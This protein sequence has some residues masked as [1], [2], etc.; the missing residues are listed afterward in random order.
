MTLKHYQPWYDDNR[1]YNTNAPSY[2]DYLANSNKL[3]KVQTEAINELLVRDVNFQD[4]DEIH[5]DKLTDWHDDDTEHANKTTFKAHVITSP[6]STTQTIDGTDYVASNGVTVLH[7]GLYAPDYKKVLNKFSSDNNSKFT[8]LTNDVNSLNSNVNTL[9]GNV[10]SLNNEIE[11]VKTSVT[12]KQNKLTATDG[13]TISGDKVS[14]KYI[15][16]FTGD[17]N[18]LTT[19]CW[20]KPADNA[21]NLPANTKGGGFLIVTRIDNVVQQTYTTID[22]KSTFIRTGS[23]TGTDT[24]N[25]L[26]WRALVDTNELTESIKNVNKSFNLFNPEI[27]DYHVFS[28]TPNASGTW[29]FEFFNDTNSK[30]F[31]IRIR[32]GKI[33]EGN[34]GTVI[35]QQNVSDLL[36]RGVPQEF[37]DKAKTE[38][39]FRAGYYLGGSMTTIGF[40]LKTKDDK[41]SLIVLAHTYQGGGTTLNNQDVTQ[42]SECQPIAVPYDTNQGNPSQ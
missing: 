18:T 21:S 10:T 8:K 39:L 36:E 40:K 41:M 6:S 31:N 1:D 35:A 29:G 2:Y 4:S 5:V 14:L 23:N 17:L 11:K 37:I 13:V 3:E 42:G 24:L 12:T 25:W 30:I 19:T 26:P 16:S 27:Y 33:V 9:S 38:I 28:N 20:V 15:N 32:C 34:E 7:D 22:N